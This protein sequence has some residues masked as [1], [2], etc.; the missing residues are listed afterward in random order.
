MK[1]ID[2][3]RTKKYR[4]FKRGNVNIKQLIYG[5]VVRKEK[6]KNILK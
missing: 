3:P 4:L 1:Y 2:I 5:E 6:D